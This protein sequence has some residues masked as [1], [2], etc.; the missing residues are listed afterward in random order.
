MIQILSK[1]HYFL[2]TKTTADGNFHLTHI[3]KD[4][5]LPNK[6]IQ[7]VISHREIDKLVSGLEKM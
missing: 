1:F 6:L 3:L 7:C 4:A 5:I 2:E